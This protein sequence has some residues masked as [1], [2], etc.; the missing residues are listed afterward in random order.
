[1]KTVKIQ[2]PDMQSIHCQMRVKSA[3]GNVSGA[4]VNYVKPGVAEV[5]LEN[6]EI[7]PKVIAAIEAAGYMVT[8]KENTPS[9]RKEEAQG[10]TLR[11]KTNIN[12]GGCVAGVT[13]ALNAAKGICHWEVDT[14]SPDKILSV[15]PDGITEEEII[16]SVQGAGF[17]IERI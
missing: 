6:E 14:N 5:V 7:Q 12:C 2:V 17:K 11:F 3:I 16:N 13:P 8:K 9:L 10:E 1:M 4:T 15:Y